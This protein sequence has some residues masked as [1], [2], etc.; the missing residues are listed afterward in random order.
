MDDQ[1]RRDVMRVAHEAR[2][3]AV[4]TC[5]RSRLLRG[6]LTADELAAEQIERRISAE[7]D[8]ALRWAAQR[9]L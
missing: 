2:A 6:T 3:T 4:E 9:Y 7:H 8:A 5:D 1:Q